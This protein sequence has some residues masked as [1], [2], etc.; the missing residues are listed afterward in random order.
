MLFSWGKSDKWGIQDM[1][2]EHTIFVWSCND[3]CSWMAI[4]HC[5]VV[6]RCYQV[7]HS[8]YS[9][10]LLIKFII[11]DLKEEIILF[12][13]WFLGLIHLMNRIICWLQVCNFLMKMLSLMPVIM[14]V[15][16]EV[17]LTICLYFVLLLIYLSFRIWWFWFCQ[18]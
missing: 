2:E 5:S 15:K 9:F 3:T 14:T 6:A 18:W 10:I 17:K 13:V 11:L 12:I 16:K 1:E 7:N 4:T 8:I